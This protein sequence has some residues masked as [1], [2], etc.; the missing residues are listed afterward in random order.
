MNKKHWITVYIDGSIPDKTIKEW[1]D[2][3]Y[4][5]VVSKLPKNQKEKL[6]NIH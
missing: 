1:I 6:E 3:S 4:K 2:E 5:L